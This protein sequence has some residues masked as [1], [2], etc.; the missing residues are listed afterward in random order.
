MRPAGNLYLR[1][2][3]ILGRIITRMHT[4]T[5]RDAGV[6]DEIAALQHTRNVTDLIT[7]LRAHSIVVECHATGISLDSITTSRSSSGR[8]RTAW[9]GR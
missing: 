8:W 1:E 5:S 4:I 6:R 9:N 7:F 3:V 2:D